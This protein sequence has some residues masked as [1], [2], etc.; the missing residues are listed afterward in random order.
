[1]PGYLVSNII[2]GYDDTE[3]V[4]RN[5]VTDPIYAGFDSSQTTRPDVLACSFFDIYN[6]GIIINDR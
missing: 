6:I 3:A 2:N 1:M 4:P 5:L